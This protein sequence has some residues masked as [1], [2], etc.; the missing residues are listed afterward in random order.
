MSSQQPLVKRENLVN[1]VEHRIYKIFNLQIVEEK[2]E[3]RA[4]KKKTDDV[5]SGKKA[6]ED[7][8]LN[9]STDS[10]KEKKSSDR[11]NKKASADKKKAKEVKEKKPVEEKETRV[12][13][14][15]EE[16]PK[17]IKNKSLPFEGSKS[18]KARN[19]RR[20]LLKKHLREK[21]KN[22]TQPIT[23]NVDSVA[24][25]NTESAPPEYVEPEYIEAAYV[26]PEYIE[27]EYTETAYLEPTYTE[28]AYTEP[29]LVDN[30]EELLNTCT[31]LIKKN[32]NKK[33][34]HLKGSKAKNRSHQH[35]DKEN[36]PPAT[37][38]LY[39]RA[40]ITVAESEA[41]PR[42]YQSTYEYPIHKMPTLF[43][44]ENPIIDE[45]VQE[46]ERLDVSEPV[47]DS[48]SMDG[49]VSEEDAPE[50]LPNN[51]SDMDKPAD[52]EK[53]PDADFV[54]NI[55]TVGNQLAIKVTQKHNQ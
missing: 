17:V 35:F 27:P 47:E 43:Y 42:T 38:N 11:K 9:R 45:P 49:N 51:K 3:K 10:K 23:N 44:A 46:N 12:D 1:I 6:S 36:E 28:Q 55:P 21:Q 5:K 24:L 25:E 8:K 39:G 22:D 4:K 2:E 7:T 26:E 19:L 41:N 30:A 48:M 31:K 53:Y 18:T 32:K 20:R 13:K 34:N 16:E 54:N 40:F 14:Q 29:P 15:K 52:Y 50:E 37:K 33:K